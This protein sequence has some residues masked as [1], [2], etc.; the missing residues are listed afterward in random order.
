MKRA[1]FVLLMAGLA[2]FGVSSCPQMA[3]SVH[4]HAGE[5]RP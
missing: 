1:A 5:A 4:L 2:L 3:E